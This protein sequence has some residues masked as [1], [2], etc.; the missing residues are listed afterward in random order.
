MRIRNVRHKS[1]GMVAISYDVVSN[2]GWDRMKIESDD[3]PLESFSH[4]IGSLSQVVANVCQFGDVYGDD[5]KA[6]GLTLSYLSNGSR[7][8]V[9]TAQK[10]LEGCNSPLNLATPTMPL[11]EDDGL[12]EE[13][14]LV[15]AETL[16]LID[17][18]CEEAKRYICGE[19]AQQDLGLF[20]EHEG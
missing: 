11:D 20:G 19:R 6:T 8:V 15:G 9:F 16:G 10:P 12:A 4:A 13:S 17:S 7:R 1:D 14:V 18:V 2:D 3:I 5:I